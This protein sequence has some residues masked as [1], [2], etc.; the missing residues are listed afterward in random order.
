MSR[1]SRTYRVKAFTLLE[2]LLVIG[3]I[4]ALG[5]VI[6]PN[7]LGQGESAKIGTT[8]IQM[9]SV[10]EALEYYKLKVGSYPTT[11][12]GLGALT[13]KDDVQDEEMAKKWDG[14]YLRK[15][16][17]LRD[18]WGRK[19]NYESPGRHNERSFD[20][21]SNGPDGREGNDDDVTNWEDDD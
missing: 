13:D 9:N 20:L 2:I 19:L 17:D 12:E 10:E 5:A 1:K 3:I 6:L 21:W 11:D 15:S 7:L 8:K 4:V 18:P 14:P 16:T